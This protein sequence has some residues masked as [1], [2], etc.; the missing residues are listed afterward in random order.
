MNQWWQMWESLFSERTCNN[1]IQLGLEIQGNE[2]RVGFDGGQIQPDSRVRRSVVRW[3]N[4]D[5]PWIDIWDRLTELV[6]EA[7]D[8]AFG[9]VIDDFQPMQFTEYVAENRGH[10]D[11]HVD[12]DWPSRQVVHR[13]LS[14]VVQLSKPDEYAVFSPVDFQLIRIS[15]ITT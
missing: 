13:K 11:W 10:Y 7:N 2:S 12:I 5:G 1:M 8:N 9:F 6:H 3:V 14:I 15:N 4:R